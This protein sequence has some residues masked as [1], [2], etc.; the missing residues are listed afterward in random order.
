VS[1]IMYR[2]PFGLRT[3]S[4]WFHVA[5]WPVTITWQFSRKSFTPLHHTVAST[6]SQK[7]YPVLPARWHF[8]S[9]EY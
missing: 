2:P 3:R 8:V 1:Q 9:M 7:T 4:D 6:E 5:K